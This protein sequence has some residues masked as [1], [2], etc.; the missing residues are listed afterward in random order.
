MTD[1]QWIRQINEFWAAWAKT[2]DKF[3]PD[4]LQTVMLLYQAFISGV[5]IGQKYLLET[6]M[7]NIAE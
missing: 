6:T 3:M 4:D 2:H 7:E 1:Q 5:L